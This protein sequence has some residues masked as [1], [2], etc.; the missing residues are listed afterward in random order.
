[1]PEIVPNNGDRNSQNIH[2]DSMFRIEGDVIDA[3]RIVKRMEKAAIKIADQRIDKS[4]R[5]VGDEMS[6]G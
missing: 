2:Y 6:F 4:W 3:D 5:D 1:M